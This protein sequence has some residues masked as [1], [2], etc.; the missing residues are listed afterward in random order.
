MK[1]RCFGADLEKFHASDP[2]QH[3]QF[4]GRILATPPLARAW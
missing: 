3:E 4:T 2:V 1:Q